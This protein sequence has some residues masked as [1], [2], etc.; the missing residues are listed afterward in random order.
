MSLLFCVGALHSFWLKTRV[1]LWTEK[2]LRS[3][4]LFLLNGV[5]PS[6]SL[7]MLPFLPA[8]FRVAKPRLSPFPTLPLTWSLLIV[9]S[10]SLSLNKMMLHLLK[11][12]VTPLAFRILS[13][14]TAPQTT[15]PVV[16]ML[17]P[18]GTL[19]DLPRCTVYRVTESATPLS[20]NSIS[21]DRLVS[22]IF[23]AD[24]VIAW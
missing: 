2:S 23:E 1:T 9:S 17:S 5:P 8:T 21:Y 13:A 3:T 14:Q 15:P 11:D 22:L 16:V 7:P 19:P 24:H 18:S 6:L 12:P 10:S 20:G 4:F